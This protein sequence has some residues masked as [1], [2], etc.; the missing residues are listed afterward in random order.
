[1]FILSDPQKSP[2]LILSVIL[3]SL[4]IAFAIKQKSSKSDVG[5]KIAPL[6]AAKE[7]STPSPAP[8]EAPSPDLQKPSPP[9][10]TQTKSSSSASPT[11]FPKPKPLTQNDVA[12]IRDALEKNQKNLIADFEKEVI[13]NKDKLKKSLTSESAAKTEL[14]ASEVCIANTKS[15]DQ[16]QMTGEAKAMLSPEM[17]NQLDQI[18]LMT[19][20]RCLVNAQVAVSLYPNLSEEAK[21]QIF[22][23]ASAQSLELAKR[24]SK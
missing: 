18:A 9:P 24:F 11:P 5:V 16:I 6:P 1:V 17:K 15:A 19:Q 12:K 21:R 14:K 4:I 13:A 22:S 23:K 2:Y 7:A 10:A 20:A 3:I 8:T